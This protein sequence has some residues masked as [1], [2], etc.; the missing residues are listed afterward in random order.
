MLIVQMY[1]SYY[2]INNVDRFMYFITDN[3]AT[4]YYTGNL[5]EKIRVN[6]A[7]NHRDSQ[8]LDSSLGCN[9]ETYH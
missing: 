6:I 4:L 2:P 3:T 7:R 8:Y 9:N 5:Q 1:N